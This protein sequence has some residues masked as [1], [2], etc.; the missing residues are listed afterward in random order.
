MTSILPSLPDGG[1]RLTFDALCSEDGSE[2]EAIIRW[3]GDEFDPLTQGDILSA[4]L[5]LSR[6]KSGRHAYADG[7]NTV[8]VVF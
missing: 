1:C 7:V 3:T 5:A 2:C 4:K 8:T 6:T